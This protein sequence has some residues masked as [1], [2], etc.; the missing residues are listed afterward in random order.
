[1]DIWES[2]ANRCWLQG[3]VMIGEFFVGFVLVSAD[4]SQLELRVLA[5]LSKD[6]GLCKLFRT[7]GDFFQ[8]VTDRWNANTSIDV[9]LDRQK[10]KQ[11]CGSASFSKAHA[12]LDF[13]CWNGL[14]ASLSQKPQEYIFSRSPSIGDYSSFLYSK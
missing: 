1:M 14:S 10:V 12:Y 7:G 6:E 9:P 5:G 4:Y 11:V 13:V 8:T 3:Y 2:S